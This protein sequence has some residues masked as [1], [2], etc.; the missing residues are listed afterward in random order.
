MFYH[1]YTNDWCNDE[2][3]ILCDFKLIEFL[4][5]ETKKMQIIQIFEIIN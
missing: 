3:V 5:I 4:F 2:I 1:K